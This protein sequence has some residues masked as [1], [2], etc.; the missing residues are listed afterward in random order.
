MNQQQK[1]PYLEWQD[2]LSEITS[3]DMRIGK[4]LLLISGKTAN[5]MKH[6]AFRTDVTTAIVYLQGSV[7]FRVNMREF[8]AEAPCM[9]L[10][11]ADAIIECLE[12]S[13]NA[14]TR[15]IVM[16]RTF[17]DNIFS[18]QNNIL[19]LYKH[20][21]DNPVIDLRGEEDALTTFYMMLKNLIRN[22]QS[23]W[24]LEAARHLTLALF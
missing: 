14:I 6:G 9:V 22:S 7:H 4:D 19:P 18:A 23:P 12:V 2:R 21:V 11:P 3:N 16:S 10:M 8:K 1:I 17:S 20:I 24:R 15:I 5:D 13:D